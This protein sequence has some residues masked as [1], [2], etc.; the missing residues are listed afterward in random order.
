MN[1]VLFLRK[2]CN[3]VP[4]ITMLCSSVAFLVGRNSGYLRYAGKMLLTNRGFC[5]K[6]CFLIHGRNNR[7]EIGE[8]SYLDGC[9]FFIQG[10]D[11]KISIGDGCS[12]KGLELWV[13]DDKG[14]IKLGNYVKQF[15]CGQLAV[16]EGKTITIGD[17]CLIAKGI[18]VRTGDS[19][20]ILLLSSN[21]RINYSQNVSIG[22][23][24]WIGANATILKGVE[25]EDDSIVGGGAIV[26]SNVSSNTVVA[27]IPAKVVKEGITWN[28]QR[29]L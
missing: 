8:G 7:I 23:H 26:T 15:D 6:C 22:N 12:L 24:V 20:S 2:V 14:T 29:L 28:I 9:R 3:R 16:I 11:C 4:Q 21:Q 18:Q 25:I 19:H 10:T 27:G 5:R 17:D 13:E 1:I